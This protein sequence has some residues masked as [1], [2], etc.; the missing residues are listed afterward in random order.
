VLPTLKYTVMRLGLFVAVLALAYLLGAR[1]LLAFALAV[2]VSAM[3]SFVLLRG[4][5]DAVASQVSNG[6]QRRLSARPSPSQDELVE[7]AA[8]DAARAATRSEEG[9]A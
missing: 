5:R 2:L 4:Q 8:V 9:Q 7:D 3:L 1:G 6:L